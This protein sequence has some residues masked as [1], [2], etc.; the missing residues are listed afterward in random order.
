MEPESSMWKDAPN[1][2]APY[3]RI[4][5]EDYSNLTKVLEIN[6]TLSTKIVEL[7]ETLVIVMKN[8]IIHTRR[9]N[10]CITSYILFLFSIIKSLYKK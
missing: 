2:K 1:R 3:E 6:I 7:K 5:L 8:K 4:L 9:N 10:V